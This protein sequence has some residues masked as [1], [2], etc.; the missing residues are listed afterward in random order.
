MSECVGSPRKTLFLRCNGRTGGGGNGVIWGPSVVGCRR[1]TVLPCDW[2]YGVVA[3]VLSCGVQA[4]GSPSLLPATLGTRQ[5]GW[6]SLAAGA[7]RRL[8]ACAQELEAWGPL[9]RW[10]CGGCHFAG[11]RV[12][13]A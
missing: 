4:A 10:V 8:R 9:A 11:V 5:V 6:V 3:L 12:C 1:G 13:R 2:Q 7:G